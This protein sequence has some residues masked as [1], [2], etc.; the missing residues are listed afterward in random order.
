LI[1]NDFSSKVKCVVILSGGPDSSTAAYWAKNEGY[2]VFGLSFNY[3][4]I[5]SKELEHAQMVAERLD[6]PLKISDLSS[7]KN[8]FEGVSSLIDDTIELTSE[9]SQPLIVPFRNGI[10]LA[11][12]TSY[13]E[14]IGAIKIF[15]GA[16]SSDSTFYPDCTIEF[17]KAFETAAQLGT[18]NKH[19]SIH[20]PFSNKTKAELLQLGTKLK[21]PYH[22]TWS[23]YLNRSK[24]CGTCESCINRRNAFKNAGLTDPT[25]YEE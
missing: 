8:I 21:V 4:Q 15:Y 7:L 12:A 18:D 9:F 17:Y 22:L 1:D 11:I 23:C 2:D 16:H 25:E 24:H 14:S 20:A 6:I 3:G 19:I 10:F 13:A 5:A